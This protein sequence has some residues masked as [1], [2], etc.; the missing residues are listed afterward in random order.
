MLDKAGVQT[1]K[2]GDATGKA[3]HLSDV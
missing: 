1:E 3:E 2:F